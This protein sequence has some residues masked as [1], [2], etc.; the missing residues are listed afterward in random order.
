MSPALAGS[1][2]DRTTFNFRLMMRAG[3]TAPI[4]NSAKLTPLITYNQPAKVF[5]AAAK[6]K[7]DNAKQHRAGKFWHTET[8]ARANRRS[9]LVRLGSSVDR[10]DRRDR[11]L[12][13]L[14]G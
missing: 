12:P 1:R 8:A 14:S 3:I 13:G 11:L 9:G 4:S 2:G 10:L 6:K 5:V 7:I